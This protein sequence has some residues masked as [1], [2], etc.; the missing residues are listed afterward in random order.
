[1]MFPAVFLSYLVKSHIL[2]VFITCDSILL[3]L[4]PSVGYLTLRMYRC[5]FL[6]LIHLVP[7]GS[8]Q[9]SARWKNLL[10]KKI[11]A[12]LQIA[13]PRIVFSVLQNTTNGVCLVK[14]YLYW[15]QFHL[16]Q[17][18]FFNEKEDKFIFKINRFKIEN[19][20]LW[21]NGSMCYMQQVGPF[22]EPWS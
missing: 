10:I 7:S 8:S 20:W 5:T 3:L 16:L 1:M 2:H 12:D 17:G 11:R 14:S 19:W 9:N 6:H 4:F 13:S 22:K 18:F 15:Y 21:L